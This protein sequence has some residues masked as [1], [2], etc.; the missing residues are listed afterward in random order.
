M[1]RNERCPLKLVVV[2]TERE[3]VLC[4][5]GLG[6][7]GISS[8]NHHGIGV[9]PQLLLLLLLFLDSAQLIIACKIHRK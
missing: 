5:V 9:D 6:V 3:A 8:H 1:G 4:W 7:R 2:E